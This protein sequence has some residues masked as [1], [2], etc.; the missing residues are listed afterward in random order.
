MRNNTKLQLIAIILEL[1][2]MIDKDGVEI[3]QALIQVWVWVD[4]ENELSLKRW[5]TKELHGFRRKVR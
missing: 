1:G 4:G 3:C 5:G 2:K